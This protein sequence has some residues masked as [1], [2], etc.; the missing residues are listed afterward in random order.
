MGIQ[1]TSQPTPDGTQVCW[2]WVAL[3]LLRRWSDLLASFIALYLLQP[4]SPT[5]AFFSVLASSQYL[6]FFSVPA[7]I[8]QP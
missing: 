8:N 3:S 1:G 2:P 7:S 6:A 5:S 4:A